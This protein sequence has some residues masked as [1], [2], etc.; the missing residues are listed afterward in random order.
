MK[1]VSHSAESIALLQRAEWQ[2]RIL[3]REEKERAKWKHTGSREGLEQFR[4][5][6]VARQE[7]VIILF[8][9][10]LIGTLVII[11]WEILRKFLFPREV[12]EVSITPR[13]KERKPNNMHRCIKMI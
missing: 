11:V 1:T 3:E 8:N 12:E 6:I 2:R 5:R 13:E 10:L 4:R 9:Y 7:T